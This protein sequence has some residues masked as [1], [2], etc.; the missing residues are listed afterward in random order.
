MKIGSILNS[1][2]WI[3]V[4]NWRSTNLWKAEIVISIRSSVITGELKPRDK[5]SSRHNLDR[6]LL[7]WSEIVNSV[8]IS[9]NEC[10]VA[11]Q[12]HSEIRIALIEYICIDWSYQLQ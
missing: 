11:M 4:T 9:Q 3:R 1:E 5:P 12:L 10:L 6:I 2:Q 8:M 7:F